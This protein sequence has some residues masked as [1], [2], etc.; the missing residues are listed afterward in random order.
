MNFRLTGRATTANGQSVGW[1]LVEGKTR[2]NRLFPLQIWKN[3]DGSNM[4]RM[5]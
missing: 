4:S 3:I 5:S 1:L 2:Q